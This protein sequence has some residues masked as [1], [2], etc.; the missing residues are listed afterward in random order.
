MP[1]RI[2]SKGVSIAAQV[3]VIMLLNQRKETLRQVGLDSATYP[4]GTARN[5]EPDLTGAVV[6]GW[7]STT[8]V[9][10]I[11][12]APLSMARCAADRGADQEQEKLCRRARARAIA[13][14]DNGLVL[15][16][17]GHIGPA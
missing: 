13:V 12:P 8:L 6:T 10:P 11:S 2:G 3:V 1:F 17:G 5:G 15:K 16:V 4:A 7:L 14:G 9:S